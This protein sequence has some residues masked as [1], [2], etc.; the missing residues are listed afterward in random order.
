M[1]FRDKTI[2]AEAAAD[3][4][5]LL[6]YAKD[7]EFPQQLTPDQNRQVAEVTVARLHR[8]YDERMQ[9][10]RSPEPVE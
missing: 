1:S 8:W 2:P 6:E 7:I 5:T 4:E 10:D 3:V 9:W